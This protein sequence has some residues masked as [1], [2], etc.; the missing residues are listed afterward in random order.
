MVVGALTGNNDMIGRWAKSPRFSF[1]NSYASVSIVMLWIM[2]AIH[3]FRI[4]Q[5][6]FFQVSCFVLSCSATAFFFI[7]F[8]ESISETVDWNEEAII[9]YERFAISDNIKIVK[10]GSEHFLNEMVASALIILPFCTLSLMLRT[11][12]FTSVSYR[13]A[14]QRDSNVSFS[15][16]F[17]FSIN[18]IS[19]SFQFL[20]IDLRFLQ[21]VFSFSFIAFRI[22]GFFL[23]YYRCIKH[24]QLS[25]YS[26]F[27]L[28]VL[29]R[30]FPFCSKAFE[31]LIAVLS[32]SHTQTWVIN[33]L[34]TQ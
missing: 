29:Q 24:L 26:Y 13:A 19:K 8:A 33:H 32:W 3:N 4:F 27:F 5:V 28:L 11:F 34:L 14:I 10:Y 16:L 2:S 15:F 6:L 25:S 20:F 31:T 22:F 9:R 21:L 12:Y 30:I 1:T 7:Y 23:N 17:S 18:L